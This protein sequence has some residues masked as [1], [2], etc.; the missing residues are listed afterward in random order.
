MALAEA[1]SSNDRTPLLGNV[2]DAH[3]DDD[4]SESHE[5]DP[6]EHFC[7]N[8]LKSFALM[9]IGTAFVAVFSD[10]MVDVITDFGVTAGIKPFFVSFIIT[11]FCSNASELLS[12]L[13]FASKKKMENSSMT[14]S[15]L[16]G[17]V[18]LSF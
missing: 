6:R 11:P 8:L 12:S 14:Y 5:A 3:E 13:I 7:R 15:Q 18:K 9:A 1:A 2:Q 16:Y 4:E 17:F 10:P